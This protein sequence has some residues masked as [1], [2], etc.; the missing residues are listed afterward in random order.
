MNIKNYLYQMRKRI[1]DTELLK[2]QS[3]IEDEI[4]RRSLNDVRQEATRNT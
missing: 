1:S 4:E 2:I 3:I